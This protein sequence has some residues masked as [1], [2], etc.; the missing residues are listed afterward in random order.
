MISCFETLELRDGRYF[1][2]DAHRERL[3]SASRALG[4]PA[5][6][7]QR[8]DRALELVRDRSD[9]GP[10]RVRI[11]WNDGAHLTLVAA[12]LPTVTQP[13][14]IV[15]SERTAVA[16]PG[17]TTGHKTIDYATAVVLSALHPSADEIILADAAGTVRGGGS[18]N[19][20]AVV[21]GRLVTP[22]L[23]SGCRDGVTRALLLAALG[24]A[25][26]EVAEIAVTVD[27]LLEADEIF[28]TSTG[29]GVQEVGWLNGEALP[30][31]RP[32]SELARRAFARV[33]D[34]PTNWS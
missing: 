24:S 11:S 1:V 27:E 26:V 17:P 28:L 33:R 34:D 21:E 8:L 19:V 29:R 6:E 4:L 31:E 7:E 18:S 23:S 32:H 25:G 13:A 16:R 22:A 2:P 12:P 10:H 30:A 9:G 3:A 15:L 20:F 5:L 14:A